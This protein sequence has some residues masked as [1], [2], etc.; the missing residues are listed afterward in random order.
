MKL[1]HTLALVAVTTV[2][3][4]IASCKK[5]K[6]VSCTISA[7]RTPSSTYYFE[8]DAAGDLTKR[9]DS[10]TG[11]YYTYTVNGNLLT[12]QN[13]TSAGVPNGS[14]RYCVVNAAGLV[15]QDVALDTTFIDYN[16]DGQMSKT[17]KG[18]GTNVAGWTTYT[19]ENG[20]L[21]TSIE[22]D[23]LGVILNT[24]SIDYYTDKPNKSNINFIYS[25]LADARYGKTTKNLIKEVSNSDGTA[26][27]TTSLSYN[28]D[29]NGYVTDFSILTQP[30]NTYQSVAIGYSCN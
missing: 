18:S 13:Y 27:R 7:L 17:T 26:I 22:Y 6:Q 2:V 21:I 3:L 5:D 12:R 9:T 16:S 23:A 19:Y 28:F 29:G 24:I 30:D 25:F 15:I 14:P 10:A 20:N 4:T 8:Y 1:L 11:I